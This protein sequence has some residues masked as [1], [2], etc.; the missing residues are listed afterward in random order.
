MR[1]RKLG[2]GQSVIFCVPREIK[3]KIHARRQVQDNAPIDVA[4]VLSWAVSQTWA[5]SERNTSLWAGQGRRFIRHSQLWNRARQ[6]GKLSAE[7]ALAFLEP[8]SQ[9]LAQRYQRTSGLPVTGAQTLDSDEEKQILARCEEMRNKTINTEHTKQ[10]MEEQE[11]EITEETEQ[12]QHVELPDKAKP[13]E[14]KVHPDLLAL[15]RTG[16]LHLLPESV[17]PAPAFIPAFIALR[18]TRL[19]KLIDLFEFPT[20]LLVT[21]DYATTVDAF[22]TDLYQRP[23][24]WVL[25]TVNRSATIERLIVLSP[26]EANELHPAIAASP[27]VSLRL[28][29]PRTNRGYKSIDHLGLD[30]VGADASR[31][32]ILP[33]SSRLTMLLNI[34]AGQL[35]FGS[36][37]EYISTCRFLGLVTANTSPGTKVAEDGFIISRTDVEG[38]ESAG[39]SKSPVAAIRELM[40][41]R[42]DGGSV[43]K[44]HVGKMLGGK[45]LDV[46]EFSDP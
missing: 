17:E 39:F 9:T 19:G 7:L 41:I 1:M 2:H 10:L 34:F 11:R 14:H 30:A 13:A 45:L 18:S 25:A 36:Y 42:C 4:E 21:T 6:E 8:E 38:D 26:F 20:D 23:I 16:R 15:V 43:E 3:V 40:L 37:E 29:S 27:Y 28:Y 12:E 31:Q 33:A 32:S 35:Y 44:S 46:G 22:A 5:E 24:Q